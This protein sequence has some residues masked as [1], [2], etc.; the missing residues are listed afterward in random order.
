MDQRYR[1]RPAAHETGPYL[2]P[3]RRLIRGALAP[4]PWWLSEFILFGLKQAW[5]CLFAAIMLAL[6]LI[7][8]AVWQEGWPVHR[9]DFLFLAALT[10]QI[11]FLRFKME[12]WDEARVILVYHVTGTVMEIFKVHMG[13]WAYP[14]TSFIQIG[15]VP[16]FSGFMYAAIGSFMARTIRIFDMRFSHYPP[17]WQTGLLAIAIYVNFFSHH[18]LPDIRYLLFAATVIVFR[19]VNIHFTTDSTTLR[20]PL[21]F[22]AFLSSAFLWLAE[23]IGTLTGTWIYPTQETWHVVSFGKLGSW[24]LLLYVSFV[25]VTLVLKPRPPE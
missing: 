5:A 7:T 23:N 13:S 16:L 11:L 17:M 9:Y 10:I 3:L 18:F 4:L 14:E 12:S 2:E 25:L 8:K 1:G 24:Y 19:R 22:A 15:G 20:M 6:L 21:V